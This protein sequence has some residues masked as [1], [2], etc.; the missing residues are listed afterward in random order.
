M[1]P[2]VRP[3]HPE[4][5]GQLGNDLPEHPR[6]GTP[7]MQ[8]RQRRPAPVLLVVGPHLA[9]VRIAGHCR[10]LASGW[11]ELRTRS[12][13]SGGFKVELL[14]RNKQVADALIA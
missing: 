14:D 1:P 12:R 9:E 5:P 10:L 8:Q 7:R 2:P 13:R 3:E 6:V 11:A 4:P